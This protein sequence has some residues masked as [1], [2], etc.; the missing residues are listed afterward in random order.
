MLGPFAFL[1]HRAQ[2]NPSGAPDQIMLGDVSGALLVWQFET[3]SKLEPLT[4][5]LPGKVFCLA[6]APHATGASAAGAPW[7]ALAGCADGSIYCIQGAAGG[8]AWR[9]AAH[10]G[11]VQCLHWVVAEGDQWH[12]RVSGKQQQQQQQEQQESQLAL[13]QHQV[14]DHSNAPTP[15][16]PAHTAVTPNQTCSPTRHPPSPQILLSGGEDGKLQ[17]WQL[18]AASEPS[19]AASGLPGEASSAAA[20][21]QE[22]SGSGPAAAAPEAP[23]QLVFAWLPKPGGGGS[24]GGGRGGGRGAASRTWAAARV[25]PETLRRDGSCLVVA[26]AFNGNLLVYTLSPGEVW[27][28]C[29]PVEVRRHV[30]G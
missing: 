30:T 29:N 3:A 22:D 10:A 27:N 14:D 23:R 8:V 2:G 4:T 25:L 19:I 6:A 17:L 12:E 7:C 16:T 5:K 1:C 11:P 18:P 24:S 13:G 28:A 9:V 20:A 21:E 15:V 26:G